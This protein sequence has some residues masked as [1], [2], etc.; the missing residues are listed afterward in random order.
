MPKKK[1][2][3]TPKRLS[4]EDLTFWWTDSPMQ[5]TT[6]AMLLVLDRMPEWTR[7]R[8]AVER[9]RG[10]DAAQ[11]A[12]LAWLAELRADADGG[13]CVANATTPIDPT[14]GVRLEPGR[15]QLDLTT[16]EIAGV[17][18]RLAMLIDDVDRG[19]LA[20]F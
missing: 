18:E 6:M 11:L 5:P 20:V 13:M 14:R 7:L 17:A 10:V 1:D 3:P 16:A 2:D 12:A 15:V 19:A 8:H 9:L 4:G